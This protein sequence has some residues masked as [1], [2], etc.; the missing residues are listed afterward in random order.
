MGALFPILIIA[1][2]VISVAVRAKKQEDARKAQ[3]ARA[4]QANAERR[5]QQPADPRFFDTPARQPAHTA[6]KPQSAPYQGSMAYSSSEGTGD[7]EGGSI[8]TTPISTTLKSGAKHV[9]KAT[10]E[11]GH[12]HVES[13][14]AYEAPLDESTD[15]TADAAYAIG[16]PVARTHTVALDHNSVINGVLYAEILQPPRSRRPLTYSKMR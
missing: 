12:T 2:V 13:S 10:S 4:Q 9:V 11:G 5:T 16:T 3:A 1:A 8:R 14:V 15:L 6:A 7:S